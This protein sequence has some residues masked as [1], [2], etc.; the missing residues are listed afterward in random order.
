MQGKLQNNREP[1][2]RGKAAIVTGGGSHEGQLGTGRATAICLA[3]EGASV[4][5]ADV[6]HENASRTVDEIRY[7][8][9]GEA[10]VFAGDATKNE[11]CRAM[12]AAAV[13]RYGG[14]HVLINNLGF[15]GNSSNPGLSQGISGID[16]EEWDKGFNLNLKSAMLASK[17]AIPAMIASGGGSIINLSS[18]DG[19]AAATH[20]GA[21]YS[22]SKGALHMLT[23]ATAAW[24]GRDGIRA[25][26]IAPG[27]L[28]SAFT[29]D[30][31]SALQ[32]RRRRVVPLGTQGTPWDVAWAAVFLASDEARW[33]SGV[34]LPVDGGL[35]AAQPLLGHDLI[36][37]INP[38]NQVKE[39]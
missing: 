10:S 35:F 25:N 20:Y 27:H 26:C 23:K 6:S 9:G 37:G 39:D 16:E 14:L 12:V 24:H 28:H 8:I 33:I 18:C 36:E 21:P 38:F 29:I 30:F 3:R 17:N 4:L 2:L 5:V 7:E 22:V 19:V 34:T 32:D 13:Q 1:R 31:D 15:G 11:D